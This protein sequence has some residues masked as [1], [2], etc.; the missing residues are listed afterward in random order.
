MKWNHSICDPCWFR[1]EGNGRVPHRIGARMVHPERCCFCGNYH[2]SG[3]LV[4]IDPKS[5]E[6]VCEDW[7]KEREAE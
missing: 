1:K 3:I 7:H 2:S 5:A 4:R 6:L